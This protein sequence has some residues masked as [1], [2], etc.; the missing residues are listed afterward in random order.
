M[1]MQKEQERWD[2]ELWS[3]SNTIGCMEIFYCVN[4]KVYVN[5]YYSIGGSIS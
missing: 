2:K 3:Q 1:K 4:G 5:C